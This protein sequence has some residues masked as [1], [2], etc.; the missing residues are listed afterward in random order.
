MIGATALHT[1]APCDECGDVPATREDENGIVLCDGCVE[2]PPSDPLGK[3]LY[4]MGVVGRPLC[5]DKPVCTWCSSFADGIA[6]S[7][8]I[9]TA[10]LPSVPSVAVAVATNSELPR[11]GSPVT[12]GVRLEPASAV[13]PISVSETNEGGS[14]EAHQLVT[15]SRRRPESGMNF[16][17]ETTEESAHDVEV[18]IG[19]AGKGPSL[20]LPERG[21]AAAT[22]TA[23]QI[24]SSGDEPGIQQPRS[25]EQGRARDRAICP[26]VSGNSSCGSSARGAS[27]TAHGKG[28]IPCAI[29]SGQF[30]SVT[31]LKPDAPG[32][33]DSIFS[34]AHP[35]P[36]CGNLDAIVSDLEAGWDRERRNS[37]TFRVVAASES[38]AN[39][40][41]ES[42]KA[43]I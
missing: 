16:G 8:G 1:R 35:G 31:L 25:I 12:V 27:A 26:A 43:S 21:R 28:S 9:A 15:H 33:Q 6:S 2:A 22:D 11:G 32:P 10:A 17:S 34:C 4:G 39:S 30:D 42:S 18:R 19:A 7:G 20:S 24:F 14:H 40:I 36:C 41:S 29:G 13:T 37:T 5:S 38:A 23:D 3:I